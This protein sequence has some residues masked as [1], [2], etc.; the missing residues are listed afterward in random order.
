MRV[1]D[2]LRKIALLRRI[3]TDKGAL[4]AE[5]ETAHRLQK[6]LMER[7]AI[8]HQEVSEASPTTTFRLNWSYW[9]ELLEDFDLCLNHFGGRGSAKVGNNSIVYIRL[10]TN[11]WRIEER[12]PSGWQPTVRDRGIRSLREYLKVHAPKSYS[13]LRR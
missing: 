11:Q 7:Y 12:S 9:R 4:P 3:S 8:R 6:L 5:R 13:L 1:E 2:A 10:A